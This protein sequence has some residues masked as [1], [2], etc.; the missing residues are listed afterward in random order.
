MAAQITSQVL[1]IVEVIGPADQGMS[2]PF[3]CR[4]E[5]GHLY[6]VKAQQTASQWASLTNDLVLSDQ[7]V[8]RLCA[9]LPSVEL[10]L[11]SAPESS[12]RTSKQVSSP[13]SAWYYCAPQQS[14][15]A[16]SCKQGNT[17]ASRMTAS[18]IVSWSDWI[19]WSQPSSR[20]VSGHAL[21]SQ[22]RPQA[23]RRVAL[24]QLGVACS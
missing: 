1:Q 4:A 22:S 14:F 18:R 5:D 24:E 16:S 15:L 6:F 2:I 23:A 21:N 3:K 8:A 20:A 7:Y 10:A 17:S 9:A 19:C 13:M 12:R 11:Q